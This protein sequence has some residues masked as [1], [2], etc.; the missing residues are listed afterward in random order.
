[1]CS[2]FVWCQRLKFEVSIEGISRQGLSLTV[3]ELYPDEAG[4]KLGD[5]PA[6]SLLSTGVKV[7]NH[8]LANVF[9][10]C[11]LLSIRE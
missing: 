6:S 5:L 8:C 3:L 7:H 10:N 1:M 2:A 4:L 9:S 11:L